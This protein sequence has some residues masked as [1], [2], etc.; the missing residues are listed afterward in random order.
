MLGVCMYIRLCGIARSQFFRV[1]LR[2]ISCASYNLT[3]RQN[4]RVPALQPESASPVDV[5]LTTTQ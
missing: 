1:N 5:G 3:M 2:S 4:I